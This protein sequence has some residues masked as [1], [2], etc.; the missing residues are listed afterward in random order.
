ML[1]GCGVIIVGGH[2]PRFAQLRAAGDDGW[3]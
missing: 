2:H 3:M 1:I